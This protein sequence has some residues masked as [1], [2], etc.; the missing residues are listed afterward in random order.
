MTRH[1]VKQPYLELAEDSLDWEP[2]VLGSVSGSESGRLHTQVALFRLVRAL[3]GLASGSPEVRV[4]EVTIKSHQIWN[5]K[6]T[7]F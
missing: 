2:T 5:C 4:W 3:A 7:D 6:N 1:I